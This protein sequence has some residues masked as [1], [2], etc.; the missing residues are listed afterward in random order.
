MKGPTPQQTDSDPLRS[1]FIRF[2]KFGG[3]AWGGP[4]A[5]IAMIKHECVDEEHWISE[6]SF[7]KLLAVFQVLPGPEAHE[8]CVYFGRLR[9]GKLGGFLAGLGFM[10]PGFLLMLGLSILYVE[11]NLAT[12]LDQLFYGLTAAVGALVARAL[13]RL[14]QTFI[15][16]V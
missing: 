12:H 3:L 1:I 16:D 9:G 8:L 14:T 2:L 11:A 7:K 15:T 6:E 10:L 5:Q 4:A 13:V